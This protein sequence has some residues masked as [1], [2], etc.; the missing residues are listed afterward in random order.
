MA[1]DGRT[2]T[3]S[4]AGKVALVTGAGQG[5]GRAIAARFL[6]EGASVAIVDVDARAGEDARDELSARGRVTVEIADIADERAIVGVVNAVVAW[7]GALDVLVNNAAIVP[8]ERVP[9]EK[10][11][12]ATWQRSLDVN[13]TAPL[14]L[15]RE[16]VPHLRARRGSI[17]NLTSTRAVMS[18][19]NTEP[20]SA[21]KGGL[22]A[23][24]HALAISLGPEIRVNAIAPG[25]IATDTWR[26][27]G[28]RHPP[29]LSAEDHAQHPVGR[30]GRPEDVAALAAWL[31]S[32]D[33]EFVTGQVFTIDGGMTRKMIYAE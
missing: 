20:Y 25:W 6:D 16:S 18:E 32:T 9:L 13:L 12:R 33:A 4:L 30:V 15:A 28:E 8:A 2:M 26:P 7:A 23:L 14:L 24:T 11:D 21:S 19:P 27:R 1:H 29:K 22:A 10:L 31:A 5:I 3:R 17:I